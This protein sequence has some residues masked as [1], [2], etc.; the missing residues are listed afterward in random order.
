[1]LAS[2]DEQHFV[3]GNKE[4][5]TEGASDSAGAVDNESHGQAPK[6][7]TIH[8]RRYRGESFVEKAGLL[9]QGAISRRIIQRETPE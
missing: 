5:A 7:D 6:A 2:G 3:T 9:F 1:V 8:C 4:A